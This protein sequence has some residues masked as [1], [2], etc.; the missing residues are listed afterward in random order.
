MSVV[1]ILHIIIA[2]LWPEALLA[3]LILAPL[4]LVHSY[5]MQTVR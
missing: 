4:L 3:Y 1:S 2:S 5:L